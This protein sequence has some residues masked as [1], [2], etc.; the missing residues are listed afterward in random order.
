MD[1]LGGEEKNQRI[2]E[3]KKRETPHKRVRG[4]GRAVSFLNFQPLPYL[5]YQYTHQSPPH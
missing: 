4:E 3:I 1:R 5:G 2:K